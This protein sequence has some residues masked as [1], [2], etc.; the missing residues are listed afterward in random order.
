MRQ[1]FALSS[2][3][4]G[5]GGDIF[6]TILMFGMIISIFYFMIIRPQSK[7]QKEREKLLS[8]IKKGDKIVTVG[9][10]HGLV[11]GIDEKTLLVE[12]AEKVKVKVERNSISVVNKVGEVLAPE[13]K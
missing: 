9:G 11:V 5:G 2:P 7:K 8:A 6:S 4:S 12:I 10:L 1:L 13:Q 3:Q